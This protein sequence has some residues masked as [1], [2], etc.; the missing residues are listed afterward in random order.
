[1][2]E[3]WHLSK[4]NL[5][6]KIPNSEQIGCVNLL[7]GTYALLS[8][9]DTLKLYS[10]EDIEKFIQLGFI[11][12]YNET[13]GL[14]FLS[15][16]SCKSSNILSLTICPTLNCNF[17][18]PYCFE[19]H[20]RKKMSKKVQN[21][22]LNFIE[23]TIRFTKVDKIYITW[24]GGEPLLA[25]DVID[26]L[27]QRMI[28]LANKWKIQYSASIVTNGFLLTQKIVD[29]LYK[30]KVM[31][32]QITLDG[33]KKTH[34][35]TRHLIGNKPTFDK[36]INNLKNIKINGNINIRHNLCNNNIEEVEELKKIINEISKISGNKLN[37]YTAFATNNEI[38]M[39]NN[40]QV[41]FLD[42][43]EYN[44]YEIDK[45]IRKI[46]PYSGS[47]CG[48]QTINFIVIDELGNLYKC[49]EDAGKIKHSYGKIE[50]WNINNPIPTADNPQILIDYINTAGAF[51]DEECQNCIWLPICQ[52]GCPQ[53]RLFYNKQCV[54]YKD[55][56]DDFVI[57][58]LEIRKNKNNKIDIIDNYK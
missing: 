46:S 20:R 54:P 27:S 50:R 58:Y 24:F 17:N 42:A 38:A 29:M 14:Q 35:K 23:R 48:A 5:F 10:G 22:I 19:K 8:Y 6:A 39:E 47:Y 56:P 49:W 40:E 18:C 3:E 53:R 26:S 34:D 28:E 45:K 57:K 51:K 15:R 16:K 9:E 4:Y 55:N 30:N 41:E 7:T 44:N 36:I 33:T 43:E 32:Y 21:D 1:M 52:G 31:S 2:S 11:V 12:N 25:Y 13:D 37:Y